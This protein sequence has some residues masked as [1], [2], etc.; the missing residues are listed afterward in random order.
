MNFELNFTILCISYKQIVKKFYCNIRKHI[1]FECIVQKFIF[2]PS[3]N[4]M[5][6]IRKGDSLVLHTIR[7]KPN[8]LYRVYLEHGLNA[9]FRII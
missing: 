7:K 4:A 3:H 5:C 9:E 2:W 6:F 1:K 8:V